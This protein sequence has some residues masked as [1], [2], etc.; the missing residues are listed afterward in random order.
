MSSNQN[1]PIRRAEEV[2][3]DVAPREEPGQQGGADADDNVAP[4]ATST[5]D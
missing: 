5:H 3:E 4:D 2:E 1:D